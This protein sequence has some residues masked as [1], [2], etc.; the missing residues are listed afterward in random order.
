MR[1]PLHR[2]RAGTRPGRAW[3]LAVLTLVGVAGAT[4]C[5][6]EDPPSGPR[7]TIAPEIVIRAPANN[8]TVLAVDHRPQIVVDVTDAGSGVF[9]SSIQGTLDGVDVSD[10]LRNG[11]DDT[12]GQISVKSPIVVADGSRLLVVSVSDHAGNEGTTQSRFTVSS[13]APPPPPSA[14]SPLP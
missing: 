8:T 1:D 7:D 10:A 3:R 9:D 11:F 4:S 12:S 6:D 13:I 2:G 5:G 14:L